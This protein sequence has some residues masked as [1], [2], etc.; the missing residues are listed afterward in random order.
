MFPPILLPILRLLPIDQTCSHWIETWWVIGGGNLE[1]REAAVRINRVSD[2]S[3]PPS[4]VS[5]STHTNVV[6]YAVFF[7]TAT[8]KAREDPAREGDYTMRQ[9]HSPPIPI[10]N[11]P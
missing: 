11:I 7:Q 3:Y 9:R 10:R 6:F 5:F 8:Q 4:H 2:L 1:C